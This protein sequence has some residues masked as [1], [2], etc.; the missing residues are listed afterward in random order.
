MLHA[1]PPPNFF[2]RQ[3]GA[4]RLSSRACAQP[5]AGDSGISHGCGQSDAS[6]L[7]ADG[8]RNAVELAYDLI[9]PIRAG[10]GMHLVDHRVAQIAEQPHKIART[11]HEHGF[12]RFG[13]DL[14]NAAW[15]L[16]C[17]FLMGLRHV[18]VPMEHGN[19]A[20][21]QKAVEPR[22]L[23]VDQALQ[24]RDIQRPEGGGRVFAQLGDDREKR[25]LGLSGGGC[26]REKHITVPL[27]QKLCRGNLHGAQA[28]PAVGINIVL[29]Q[30][31]KA[32]KH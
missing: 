21:V 18:A 24:R 32:G 4:H 29:D 9:A 10:Q 13:R 26:R 5:F 8:A 25:R 31:R 23:V 1:E 11:A 28:L 30:G 15:V 3:F 2:F 6:R 19:A 22:K 17:L 27:K 16:H 12:Q 20:H 7:I 14:Q